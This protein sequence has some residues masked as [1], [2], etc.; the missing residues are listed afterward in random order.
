MIY[1]WVDYKDGEGLQP[2]KSF[3]STKVE[4]ATD[5][6]KDLRYQGYIAKWGKKFPNE[7]DK[8]VDDAESIKDLDI[9]NI[10]EVEKALIKECYKKLNIIANKY[11]VGLADLCD[12]E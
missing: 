9:V 12:Y 6:I 10:T 5:D 2:F 7:L 3:I 11:D 1:V 4:D 8:L